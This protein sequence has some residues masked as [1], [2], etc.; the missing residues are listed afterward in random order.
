M[1][2]GNKSNDDEDDAPSVQRST[3]V[4]HHPKNLIPNIAG[5]RV[6][7]EEGTLNFQVEDMSNI[8][9]EVEK[10]NTF[11]DV[12]HACMFQISLKDGLKRFGKKE[13]DAGQK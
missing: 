3:R 5:G 2:D 8:T 10:N 1:G 13:E 6:P 12:I 11:D 9:T 4:R 7:Y